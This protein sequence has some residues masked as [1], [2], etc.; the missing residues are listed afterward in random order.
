MVCY[1]KHMRIYNMIS[2]YQITYYLFITYYAQI[3]K[4]NEVIQFFFAFRFSHNMHLV[5]KE[6]AKSY[7]DNLTN[8]LPRTASGDILNLFNKFS[9]PVLHI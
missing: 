3:V 2:S 5:A 9:D 1:K 6:I 4:V 8:K 7:L